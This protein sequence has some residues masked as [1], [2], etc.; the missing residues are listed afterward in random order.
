MDGRIPRMG[1]HSSSSAGL[2]WCWCWDVRDTSDH[3]A[4]Q[5]P[6]QRGLGRDQGVPLREGRESKNPANGFWCL[7]KQC[8]W[9]YERYPLLR[10]FTPGWGSEWWILVILT[11]SV[12]SRTLGL[13][14]HKT[15]HSWMN[16]VFISPFTFACPDCSNCVFLLTPPN[17]IQADHSP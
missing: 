6:V 15:Y 8:G 13:Y 17:F 7:A 4:S 2:S 14:D 11:C 1:F 16:E 12:T 10:T 3:R 5:E 9:Q